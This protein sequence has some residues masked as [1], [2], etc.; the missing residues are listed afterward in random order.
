MKVTTPPTGYRAQ[1]L[2]G[3][4]DPIFSPWFVRRSD[5][6]RLTADV[7]ALTTSTSLEV[8]LFTKSRDQVGD[9]TEVDAGTSIVLA[10]AGRS[11][12]EWGPATGGGLRELV[13]YRFENT[14]ADPNKW[15][16]FRMLSALWFDAVR[17]T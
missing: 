13:R 8:R 3:R 17:A 10:N 2:R 1:V 16:V 14:S 6:A 12:V 15:V 11:T 7:I 4:S 5:F 9:G